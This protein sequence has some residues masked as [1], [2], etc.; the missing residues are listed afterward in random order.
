ML[1]ITGLPDIM[2]REGWAVA[3]KCMD[4]WF[5]L[6]PHAMSADEKNRADGDG[7]AGRPDIGHRYPDDG[8]G[9]GL[10]TGQ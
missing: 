6:G 1:L 7:P 3:A 9:D 5:R 2:R 4:R 10:R 8:L